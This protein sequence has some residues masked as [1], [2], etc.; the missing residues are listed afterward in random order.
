MP[1]NLFAVQPKK[2]IAS[3]LQR[4]FAIS[5]TEAFPPQFQ[6][7]EIG[8]WNTPA[9]RPMPRFEVL[10]KLTRGGADGRQRA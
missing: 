3:I 7:A 2:F 1:F 10:N 6:L 4:E 8:F 5:L 9:P